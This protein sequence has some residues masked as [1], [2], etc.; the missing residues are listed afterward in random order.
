MK[1]FKRIY[2]DSTNITHV[3]ILQYGYADSKCIIH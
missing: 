2:C 1:N 3:P